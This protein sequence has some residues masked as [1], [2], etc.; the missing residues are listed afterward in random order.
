MI[1]IHTHLLPGVD[2]G[3]RTMDQSVEVLSRFAAEGVTTL[4]CTPHL[5]ASRAAEAPRARN[6]ALLAE[7][8]ERMGD[9][10]ELR[11]G[12]EIMLDRPGVDLSSGVLRLGTSTAVL[13]EFP[14]SGVPPRSTFELARLREAGVVPVLAHPERYL[15]ASVSQVREWRSAGA[16]MQG[17]AT[18][19]LGTG[20]K[21]RLAQALLEEGLIDLLSS[22]NHGD[23]RSLRAARDWLLEMDASEHAELLT[24]GNAARLL[25]DGMTMPVPPLTIPR[26]FATRLRELLFGRRN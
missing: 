13:V 5:K 17:D 20:D 7:L 21:G 23:Q 12:W 9:A 11:L 10:I 18:F 6:E 26:G 24:G 22:D 19:L 15:G 2:D 16:V 4:V 1:D 8:R 14:H 3:S 25:D